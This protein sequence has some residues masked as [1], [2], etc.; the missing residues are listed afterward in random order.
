M[1][2]GLQFHK[3]LGG[4]RKTC[5]IY[6]QSIRSEERA[7]FFEK[8]E[9]YLLSTAVP[10]HHLLHLF[11]LCTQILRP[12]HYSV[13]A[14]IMGDMTARTNRLDSFMCCILIAS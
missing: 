6:E 10:A 3:G 12:L 13:P 11:S 5:A 14:I 4:E 7:L 2:K 1:R 8:H 9:L